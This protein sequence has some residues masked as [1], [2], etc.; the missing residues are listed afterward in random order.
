[1]IYDDMK[2]RIALLLTAAVM[3]VSFCGCSS[4]GSS[5]SS[6]AEQ[7]SAAEEREINHSDDHSVLFILE[8]VQEQPATFLL[9]RSVPVDGELVF[10]GIPSNASYNEKTVGEL[11]EEKKARAA[12]SLAE[13]MLDISIDWFMELSQDSFVQ[14]CDMVSGGSSG[15]SIL[16]SITSGEGV[17]ENQ[18]ADN[19]AEIISDMVEEAGGN[20]LADNIDGA[21]SILIRSTN[22]DIDQSDF[23]EKSYAI[24]SMLRSGAKP[25][26]Y[27]FEGTSTDSD[28]SFFIDEDSAAEF[29]EKY[30]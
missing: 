14:L 4:S 16:E 3:S 26:K 20:Y 17:T 6:S 2:H 9:M 5:S 22:N 15:R 18:R 8:G 21:F 27:S 19:A 11:Y 10:A 23:D 24:K 1:M 7:T 28:F 30:Y 25:E 13:S 29:R 12:V